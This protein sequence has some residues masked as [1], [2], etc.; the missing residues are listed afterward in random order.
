MNKII[1]ITLMS[2]FFNVYAQEKVS[3]KNGQVV[4][5]ASVP[6]FEE[7]KATTKTASCV[8]NTSNGEMASLILIK[9]FRFKIALME[10]HFNE[11]YMDSDNFPKA[12]LKGKLL[13]FDQKKL[14][15]S[16]QTFT[17]DGKL[18]MHG[19]SLDVKIPVRIKK[20]KDVIEITSDFKINTS[21][22]DIK[23]PAAVSK[24]VAKEVEVKVNYTLN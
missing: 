23:I 13:N 17:L 24:K 5:E 15:E 14:T 6:A 12:T 7:V 2:F 20:V 19:K 1:F 18:D 8:L 4:F 16:F 21:D 3:T 22:F 9:S 11:N 10:E